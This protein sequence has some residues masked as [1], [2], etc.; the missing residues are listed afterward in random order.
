MLNVAKNKKAE[1]RFLRNMKPAKTLKINLEKESQF[2]G[3]CGFAEKYD[4]VLDYDNALRL[5]RSALAIASA[6][7]DGPIMKAENVLD[8]L[9]VAMKA[10]DRKIYCGKEKTWIYLMEPGCSLW[11]P[12][13]LLE[14]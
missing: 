8:L 14:S 2:C 5:R 13:P 11:R 7:P 9:H 6:R 12:R 10:S 4:V 3:V 1:S